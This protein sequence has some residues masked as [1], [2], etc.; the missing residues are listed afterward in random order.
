MLT[1]NELKEK[2]IEQMSEFDVV[3]LLGLTTEDIVNAFEDK[4]L[5]KYNYLINELELSSLEDFDNDD[6]YLD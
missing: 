6:E 5:A 1:L 4:L 2:V 3:D